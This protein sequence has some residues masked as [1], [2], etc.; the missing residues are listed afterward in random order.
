MWHIGQ[1]KNYLEKIVNVFCKF[2]LLSY[3]CSTKGMKLKTIILILTAVTV[4]SSCSSS[5]EAGADIDP[6]AQKD[7]IAVAATGGS[8]VPG[9]RATVVS[10]SNITDYD[11]EVWAFYNGSAYMGNS[12][13]GVRF[14][15]K[16]SPTGTS[17]PVV[18]GTGTGYW[19]Y[20]DGEVVKYWPNPTFEG[21]QTEREQPL[22]FFAVCPSQ[23]YISEWN[24]RQ[25]S[26]DNRL[27]TYTPR[28]GENS[29]TINFNESGNGN[30]DGRMYDLMYATKTASK[31]DGVATMNFKHA[32]SQ[33]VFSGSVSSTAISVK[34]KDVSIYNVCR[35]GTLTFTDGT[36]IWSV[37]AGNVRNFEAH[38]HEDNTGNIIGAEI[39]TTTPVD[40]TSEDPLFLIPQTITGASITTGTTA[41]AEGTTGTYIAVKCKVKLNADNS[42]I[43]GSN[44]AD[45]GDETFGTIYAPLSATWEPGKKY[46]INLV[47]NQNASGTGAKTTVSDWDSEE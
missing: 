8:F 31:K 36:P 30:A 19:D 7:A 1:K 35:N 34:V 38:N 18:S 4:L 26:N 33:I 15:H 37:R 40:I 10:N 5:D 23:K 39:T 12:G 47:F 17:T 6:S 24:G 3:L 45:N 9:T 11:F 28:I 46:T 14:V 13:Q 22:D 21:S 32:L 43:I 2:I 41:P 27:F 25:S 20:G 29:K 44:Y 42:M 16:D